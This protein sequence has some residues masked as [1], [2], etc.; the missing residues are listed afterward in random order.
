[1]MQKKQ[2]ETD[3]MHPEA[4]FFLGLPTRPQAFTAKSAFDLVYSCEQNLRMNQPLKLPGAAEVTRW[5]MAG[6]LVG[7]LVGWCKLMHSH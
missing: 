4:P 7:W 2:H 5:C 1:M 3:N 6:W